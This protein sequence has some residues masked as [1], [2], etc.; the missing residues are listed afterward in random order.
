MKYLPDAYP[1]EQ[2]VDNCSTAGGFRDRKHLNIFRFGMIKKIVKRRG[3]IPATIVTVIISIVAWFA[4]ANHCA[5][6]VLTPAAEG[7]AA[8]AHCHSGL[9]EP[10][11]DTKEGLP[12]CKVLRAIVASNIEAPASQQTG[13]IAAQDFLLTEWL[14]IDDQDL[15]PLPEEI[16][17]GP[18]FA[19]SYAELILQRSILSHA[20]P[21]LV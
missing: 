15:Q 5:L 13:L 12:C 8:H 17:T 9:P 10:A 18:P 1:M 20:P 2:F 7:L 6:A 14:S 11:K 21:S 4:A 19:S 3:A 16:D